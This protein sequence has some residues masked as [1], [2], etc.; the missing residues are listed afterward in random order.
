[1]FSLQL[2]DW[3]NNN[4]RQSDLQNKVSLLVFPLDN[5]DLCKK[6]LM[7]AICRKEFVPNVNSRICSLHFLPSDFVDER[8]DSHPKRRKAVGAATLLRRR[9]K[10][11]LY[12]PSSKMRQV[13]SRSSSHNV[14]QPKRLLLA[15]MSRRPHNYSSWSSLSLLTTTCQ[16]HHRQKL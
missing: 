1:M 15:V 11:M 8:Y 12:R 7:K 14:E 2:Q 4:S 3:I 9:L 16:A 6:K 10:T 13:I 5:H